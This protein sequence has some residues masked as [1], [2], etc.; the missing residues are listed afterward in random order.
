MA[1]MIIGLNSLPPVLAGYREAGILRRLST[2][3]LPPSW[4]LAAQ[5]ILNACLAVI[6]IVIMVL[7]G[8]AVYGLR[9]PQNPGG[10]VIACIVSILAVFSLGLWIAAVARTA[11][12]ASVIG[13]ACFFPLLFFAG[14]WYPQQDMAPPLRDVSHFIPLGASVQALQNGMQGS[15][16]PASSLLVL[17][18]WALVAGFLA[19]RS[20]KWE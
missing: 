15:F 8:V 9:L 1:L 3:P 4:V 18:G 19:V 5:L 20:F 7:L 14:L 17:A 2:T 10:F 16:P 11:R 6:S 12:A 13:G